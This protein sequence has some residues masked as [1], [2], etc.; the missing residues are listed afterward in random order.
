MLLSLTPL[1]ARIIGVLLEKESTTPDQYPLSLN[2]LTLGCNQKSNREPVLE[3]SEQEVQQ[4][5]D[6]LH[7][8]KCIFNITSAGS[9][10][11][12]YKHRF[13]NTEFSSLQFTAQQRAII[14]VLL[15][16]GPQTPGELRTR[17][18]RLAEFA[19]VDEVESSLQALFELKGEKIVTKL[20]REPGKRESRYAHLF[21]GETGFEL[22]SAGSESEYASPQTSNSMATRVSEL[23]TQ[24][25]ELT[26]Q[27]AELREMVEILSA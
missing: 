8:K 20:A 14:C 11:T 17:T 9:R 24:V 21:C 15:L 23:E 10:V 5:L 13:C 25:D 1:Q 7:E 12:K 4:G 2:G 27:L 22:P 18:Q 3:L 16:R 19:N 26:K 6:E